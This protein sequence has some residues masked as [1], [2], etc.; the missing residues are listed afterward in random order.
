M[1]VAVL[2]SGGVDS[3]VAAALLQEA[4]YGVVGFTLQLWPKEN[5]VSCCGLSAI[6]DARATASVLD[7]PHYVLNLCSIFE[8]EVVDYFC[9]SYL[10]G[11]TPNPCV[12][13]NRRI[14]FGYFLQKAKE[15][16]AAFIATGHYARIRKERSGRYLLLR[17]LDRRCDQSYFLAGLTPETLSSSL[18]PLGELS[19]AEVRKK[20]EGWRLP[21]AQKK[22]SQEACFIPERDY[23]RFIQKRFPEAVR[24]GPILTED[25]QQ[26]GEHKGIAFYT[27]GQRTGLGVS[28]P[29]PLYVIRI[30]PERNALVV[31]EK[32][33]AYRKEFVAVNLNWIAEKLAEP[34]NVTARIRHRSPETP[35]E[36]VPF[37]DKVLVTLKQPQ[38]AITPGQTVVFYREEV[39]VGSGVIDRG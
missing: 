27:V 33:A 39:I 4:G 11:C 36:I 13:C 12:V 23:G 38:F 21:V 8:Q 30:I 1:R 7:I 15:V 37:N 29:K 2:M 25:G 24:P 26:L 31:A 20:A 16:D 22:A 35:A 5:G 10:L 9:R 19:K 28:Q 18:F 3:A 34:V 32:E 14:K 6:Q 17:A